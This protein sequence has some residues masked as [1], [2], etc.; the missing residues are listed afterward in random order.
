MA[1]NRFAQ[2]E[3]LR[4]RSDYPCLSTMTIVIV[5]MFVQPGGFENDEKEIY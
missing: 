2:Y 5:M 4:H 1:I 3:I